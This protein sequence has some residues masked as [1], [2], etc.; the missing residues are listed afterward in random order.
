[1]SGRHWE[2]DQVPAVGDLTDIVQ[3][4]TGHHVSAGEGQ[5]P[6]ALQRR[7]AAYLALEEAR[8]QAPRNVASILDSA[9]ELGIRDAQAAERLR[10]SPTLRAAELAVKQLS[11]SP[12]MRAAEQLRD[13]PTM[14]AAELAA[15]Q[16]TDSP[17]MRAA[18]QLGDSPTMRAAELAARAAQGLSD[19]AGGRTAQGFPDDAGGG[20]GGRAAQGLSDDAGGRT[21]QGFPDDAGGGAGCKAAQGLSDDAGR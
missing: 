16:L 1:M 9:R 13:S 11:D 15:K 20:A 17:M 10:D 3:L 12:M 8:R 4:G 19:D 18:E 6:V 2:L 7:V 14:R 5:R 21:A